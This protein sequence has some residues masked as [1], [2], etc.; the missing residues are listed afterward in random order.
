MKISWGKENYRYR[1]EN[2][3]WR[4]WTEVVEGLQLG[5]SQT[6]YRSVG[7]QSSISYPLSLYIQLFGAEETCMY[8]HV[9]SYLGP[10]TETAKKSLLKAI[11]TLARAELPVLGGSLQCLW[12]LGNHNKE[13]C[14]FISWGWGLCSLRLGGPG[15]PH[16]CLCFWHQTAPS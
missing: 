1:R 11:Y 9:C 7:I 12:P 5:Y 2:P 6:E 15:E 3:P 8:T 14:R 16:V 4:H 10:G 13:Q